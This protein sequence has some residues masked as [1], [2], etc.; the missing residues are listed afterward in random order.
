MDEKTKV[1]ASLD[2]V[3]SAMNKMR[4]KKYNESIQICSSIL[5]K[6]PRDKVRF[7]CLMKKKK[8][9]KTKSRSSHQTGCMVFE[10]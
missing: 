6:N 9:K 8:K 4:S 10:M 1:Y 2:P 7:V 5:E 3:W